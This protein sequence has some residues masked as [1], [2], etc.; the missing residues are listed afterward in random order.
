MSRLLSSSVLSRELGACRETIRRVC[1][2]AR[3]EDR[4]CA[5]CALYDADR[6][7]ALYGEF[8]RGVAARRES[9]ALARR[10]AR[11]RY[12][13]LGDEERGIPSGTISDSDMAAWNESHPFRRDIVER[14]VCRV[15]DIDTP[16]D[17]GWCYG[18]RT[19][20]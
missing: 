14:F 15:H 4:G 12:I 13:G 20:K 8:R 3:V 1:A 19:V 18:A 5:G 11:E 7:T 10:A 2:A 17:R 16:V 6:A 9:A